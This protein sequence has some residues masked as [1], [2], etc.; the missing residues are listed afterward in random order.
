MANFVREHR[1][2]G[3]ILY[4]LLG[5]KLLCVGSGGTV[6]NPV[7][8][9]IREENRPT[10]QSHKHEELWLIFKE[11]INCRIVSHQVPAL[12]RHVLNIRGLMY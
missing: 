3:R 7:L 10:I 9:F 6:Y 4:A 8:M 12:I 2:S 1:K 11:K 5:V